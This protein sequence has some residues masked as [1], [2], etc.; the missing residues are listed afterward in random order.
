MRHPRTVRRAIVVVMDALRPDA[1][2]AFDLTNLRHVVRR[3][4]ATL[5]ATT[6]QPSVT[7]A[8][9]TSL[10]TGVSPEVHGLEND[11]FQIPHP[12]GPVMPL[13]R[14]LAAG[15]FPSTA[16]MAEIPLIFRPVARQIVSRLGIGESRF[17]GHDSAGILL[18]AQ[19]SLVSQRRGLILMHWPDADRA[20]HTHGWMSPE[21]AEAARRMDRA[22]GLLVSAHNILTDP[23]TV[24]IV[25]ADHGGGGTVPDDH[26]S[27]HV[28]DVTIPIVIAGGAVSARTLPEGCTLLDVPPT[29]LWMLGVH[30]PTSYSG[31]AL[32]EAF[33]TV[34]VTSHIG[35]AIA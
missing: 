32:K 7:A 27:D 3:G 26:E 14:A 20:G 29:I 28:L 16:L 4:A 15:G 2:D 17:A 18:A 30:A 24:L 5:T 6:V 22:L 25:V 10:L 23:S 19:R 33:E 8:A 1:I 9:M 31:R 13:P 21:Y 34:D 11:R 12:R 35:V